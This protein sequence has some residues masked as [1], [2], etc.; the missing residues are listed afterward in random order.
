MKIEISKLTP[1]P[2]NSRIYGH[3]D[4]LN[5]LVE[6]IKTTGWIKPIMIT[7]GNMIISGHR[8]VA[9]C[10]RLGI[11]EVEFEL[12]GDDP[13]RQLELLVM[14]N[15]YRVKTN[16]QLMKEAEICHDI[17]KKKSY[18]R[19]ISGVTP[20]TNVSQGRT[21]EL[22]SKQIGIGETSY[23]KGRKVMEFVSD[24]PELEW[25]FENT[26]NESIDKSLQL[27]E[28]PI[29]FIERV[30]ERVNGNKEK[31]LPVIRE[32]EHEEKKSNIDLP[33]GQFGVLII[34]LTNRFIADLSHT[35][36]SSAC[37]SDCILFMWVQPQQLD[38]GIHISKNWGFSYYTCMLWSKDKKKEVTLDGE[39]LM[40]FVKGSPP[41]IFKNFEG[42]VEK[43]ELVGEIIKKGYPNMDKVELIFGEGWKIW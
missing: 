22:V 2:L 20:E 7:A 9:A 37:E 41:I 25:I 5:E 42:S 15:F 28:K 17:E 13:I 35:D 39:I 11:K 34:D 26:M 24:N 6:K 16:Y 31:I 12:V 43:P 8:R 14:E 33:P 32:L 29:E 10:E 18:Q 3:E 27:T 1:H 19:M 40:V 38:A 36:I 21:S 23:K 4:N 30:V